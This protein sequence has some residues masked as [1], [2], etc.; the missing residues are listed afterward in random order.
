ML[1]EGKETIP[2]QKSFF[3]VQVSALGLRSAM[4]V[5]T[6]TIGRPF[7]VRT[8]AGRGV[9]T[10]IRATTARAAAPAATGCLFVLFKGFEIIN[11]YKKGLCHE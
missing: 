9:S 6:V 1:F 2:L 4:P 3:P 11:A 5:R 10:S 8:A 7:R